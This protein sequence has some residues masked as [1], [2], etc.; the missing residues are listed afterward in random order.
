MDY[1]NDKYLIELVNLDKAEWI[2]IDEE[3]AFTEVYCGGATYKITA[4]YCELA[5]GTFEYSIVDTEYIDRNPR[6]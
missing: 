5:D 3:Y 6:H 1:V 4:E 2:K